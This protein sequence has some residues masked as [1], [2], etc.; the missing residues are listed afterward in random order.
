MRVNTRFAP[1]PTGWLHIGGVRTALYSW[2]YARKNNGKFFL[3]IDDTDTSRS[4]DEFKDSII[5]ALNQLGLKHDNEITYQSQR[6]GHYIDKVE[7]LLNKNLAYYDKVEKNEKTRE[8]D[9]AL[10]HKNRLNKDGHIIRF[11]NQ[12]QNMI[13][14]TDSVHGEIKFEPKVFFDVVILRSN[15]VPT[16]NLTSVV[17]DIDMGITHLIRGD[18]HLSNIPVQVNLFN[19]FEADVPVF[20][21][22]PMIHGIDGKR[23]SKRHGAVDINHFLSEGYRVDALI[24]YLVKTGWSHGD[25]E[26]FSKKELLELFDLDR[27]TKSAATFDIDKLNWLNQYYIKNDDIDNVAEQILPYLQDQNLSIEACNDDYLKNILLLGIEREFSL[28]NIASSITYFYQDQIDYDTNIIAKYDKAQ[29]IKILKDIVTK[30][31]T[32][33]F[34]DKPSISACVTSSCEDLQLKFKDIGPLIRFATTG[35]LN[36]PSIDDLCFLLGKKRVIERISRLLEIYK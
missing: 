35:K 5:S 12:R 28:K 24:N 9:L 6:F 22:L 1:S 33:D 23:L 29:T 34:S 11:R 21:H 2:L 36:A 3:R 16:Y 17:D 14:I 13:N 25:K 19:S 31:F 32:I 15:G 26:I 30:F 27:V 10:V 4:T 20:C 18:D 7:E 8:T